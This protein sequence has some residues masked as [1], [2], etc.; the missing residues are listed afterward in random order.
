MSD[1]MWMVRAGPKSVLIQDF[2][3]KGYVGVGWR[4]LGDLSQV[5]S[6]DELAGLLKE[7]Y[8]DLK[9]RRL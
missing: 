9:P 6:K 2:E 4:K 1:K 3:E 8:A 5:K 7:A